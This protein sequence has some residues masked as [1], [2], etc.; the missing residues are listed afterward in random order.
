MAKTNSEL[1]VKRI[2]RVEDAINLKVPDRVPCIPRF[3]FFITKYSGITNYDAFYHP[4]KWKAACKK[5]ITDFEPDMHIIP[6]II[7]GSVLEVLE[8]TQ[9]KWPGH[10]VL[11]GHSYQ[12]L[13][14]DF[15]RADEYEAFLNDPS[16]FSLR[17]YL[18]RTFGSLGP[19][20]KLPPLT[21][22]LMGPGKISL[23]GMLAE[24][25]NI[26]AFDSLIKA[27]RKMKRWNSIMDSLPSELEELGY[28]AFYSSVTRPPYD[29]IQNFLRGTHGVMVDIHKQP[30]KIIEACN[31]ILPW[32]IETGIDTALSSNNPRVMIPV[33]W[34]SDDFMSTKQ[35]E[36][37]FF[38]TLKKLVE[39]LVAK[40]LTPIVFFEGI[41]DSRLEYILE[42][43]A[44]R[45]VAQFDNTDIFKAKEVLKNHACIKGN[46]PISLLKKGSPQEI[47]DHCKKLIDIV[48]KGGGFIFDAS[49]PLDIAKPEKV[50]IMIDFVQKYGITG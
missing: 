21:D 6:D 20:R 31:K 23:T 18:P 40:D 37:L 35:F 26:K 50:K 38:P 25:E 19:F 32:M 27:G 7:P 1:L 11:P 33:H 22:L 4:A 34:G 30:D 15:M 10:G 2:K 44:G 41:Y 24:P 5:T 48:G 3:D 42:L 12:V 29:V 47:K 43:P 28:T 16:D 39:A 17:S 45:L 13:D 36:T 46:L 49:A 8:S 14:K 9:I